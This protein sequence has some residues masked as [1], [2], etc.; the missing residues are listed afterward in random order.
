MTTSSIPV[1][2]FNPGQVFACMGFLESAEILLGQAKGGFNWNHEPGARF[3]LDAG[4][5]KNPVEAVL[6]FLVEAKLQRLAPKGY[7]DPPPTNKSKNK[8]QKNQKTRAQEQSELADDGQLVQVEAFPAPKADHLALPL[9]LSKDGRAL[10]IAHWCDGSSRNPFK[11]F[12]GQ[13]RSAA[14]AR[15]MLDELKRLWEERKEELLTDPLGLM[16]SLGGSSF[17]FDARKAWTAIDA[18]YSPD[19]QSHRVEASPVVELLAAI[20]L[21]HARPDEFDTREVR[22]GVWQGLLPPVLARAT[23]GGARVGVPL[24]IFRFTLELAGKNKNVT[25]AKED[26]L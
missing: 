23:L 5:S 12:A 15:Q 3:E 13:Q 26:L 21:E 16:V 20:G 8:K 9:R 6:E 10:D 17:K 2:L 25:F 14:I 1:D 18:G 24:R 7:E 19:E 11:L 4:D 22:Y